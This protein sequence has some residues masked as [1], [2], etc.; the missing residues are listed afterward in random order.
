MWKSA[1]R[2]EEFLNSRMDSRGETLR[3]QLRTPIITEESRGGRVVLKVTY[4][5]ALYEEGRL[6]P[7]T[8]GPKAQFLG[9]KAERKRRYHGTKME[10]MYS[11][12]SDWVDRNRG[13]RASG[14]KEAGERYN[15]EARGVYCHDVTDL[16]K[17]AT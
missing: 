13:L 6:P 10:A 7:K 4:R 8:Y 16:E 15:A 3:S 5:N 17:I 2:L 1:E 12:L 11:I 14:D 9:Q